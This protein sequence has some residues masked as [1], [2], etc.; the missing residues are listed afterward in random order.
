MSSSRIDKGRW[1]A[2]SGVSRRDRTMRPLLGGLRWG[3]PWV[4]AD[5]DRLPAPAR[6]WIDVRG[7]CSRGSPARAA[8]GVEAIR[9]KLRG[10]YGHRCL[11][12]SLVGVGAGARAHRGSRSSRAPDLATICRSTAHVV[13]GVG[14]ALACPVSHSQVRRYSTP[15]PFRAR[16]ARDRRVQPRSVSR[17]D[18]S[19]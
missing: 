19:G 17:R 7:R 13:D 3:C 4:E 2:R 8:S 11:R 12:R 16:G 18:D 9:P 15:A 6:I 1:S 10:C 14:Y 5:R